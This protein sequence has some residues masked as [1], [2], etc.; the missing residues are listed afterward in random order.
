[1]CICYSKQLKTMF[2]YTFFF[3]FFFTPNVYTA[4]LCMF[5]LLYHTFVNYYTLEMY[6]N[7]W[8]NYK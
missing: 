7:I 2:M 4:S 3:I 1:M 8:L 5:L 6:E